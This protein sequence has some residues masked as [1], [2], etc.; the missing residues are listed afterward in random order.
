M[1]LLRVFEFTHEAVQEWEERFAPQ[2]ADQ[3]RCKRKG[4][5]A[6][7]LPLRLTIV[8]LEDLIVRIVKIVF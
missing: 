1:F 4:K 2:L 5:V 7:T 3:I 8:S 6:G